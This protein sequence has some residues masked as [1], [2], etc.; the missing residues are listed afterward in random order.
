M[1]HERIETAEK[2][3]RYTFRNPELL[4]QALSHASAVDQ[5]DDSNERLEFLG[6]AVLGFIVCDTTFKMYPDYEEGEMT[7]IKS[8]VVSRR[9]CADIAEKM[10][11]GDLLLLGKGMTSRHELPGSVT[12]AAF[13]AI[14]GAIY[15]DGGFD[16]AKKFVLWA[17]EGRIEEAA[18]SEH[19]DN[20]K[21]VL[22]Q[23]AQQL[24]GR[25]PQYMVLDEKGPDH[26]K[27]FEVSVELEGRQFAPRW[28]PSKK[29]AEQ[30]AAL[31]ALVELGAAREGDDGS[32]ELI[33]PTE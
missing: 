9:V 30:L 32:V 14:I 33:E 19:Q 17:I 31:A 8:A 23:V 20:Y 29:Q 26:A 10:G 13:E 21:S 2:A 4:W 15:V 3:I 6:D 7:K 16:S 28:G 22:Q 18:E 11:L 27:C 24:S 1:D 12:G 5:R 25:A